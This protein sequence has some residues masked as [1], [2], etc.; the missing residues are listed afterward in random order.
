[1]GV[2][3]AISI[4]TAVAGAAASFT[5]AAQANK[6]AKAAQKDADEALNKARQRLKENKFAGLS[7]P[8]KAFEQARRDAQVTTA[9]ILKAA[10]EG[11]QRGVAATAGK[12]QLAS[13]KGTERIASQVENRLFQ[14]D[15]LKAKEDARLMGLNV[16]LDLKEIQGQQAAAQAAEAMAANSLTAGIQ[17]LGSAL[18][19]GISA[20][21][22]NPK[23][24]DVKNLETAEK[25]VERGQ[26]NETIDIE[27]LPQY[28][29]EDASLD[30]KTRDMFTNIE[31]KDGVSM[32]ATVNELFGQLDPGTQKEIIQ[33]LRKR[34]NPKGFLGLRGLFSN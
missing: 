32:D 25:L 5:Q 33:S 16:G 22:D 24:A 10:T 4:G 19:T 15:A 29:S 7:I 30:Q 31:V 34:V 13:D 18:S 11:D 20:L 23:T 27:D 17:G 26:K 2:V 28:I 14:I 3:T 8:K 12:V 1:M 6:K 9:T 21:S